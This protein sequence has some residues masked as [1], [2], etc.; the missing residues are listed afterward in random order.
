M[1]QTLFPLNGNP[2]GLVP[3]PG[4]P[5]MFDGVT[6]LVGIM[7][8]QGNQGTSNAFMPQGH[9]GTPANR[10]GV[11]LQLKAGGSSVGISQ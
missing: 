9:A 1:S 7:S 3:P 5:V 11:P 4:T 10:L 8:G 2:M 6:P